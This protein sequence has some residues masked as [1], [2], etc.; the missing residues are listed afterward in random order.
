CR[1]GSPAAPAPDAAGQGNPR[2]AAVSLRA[3]G[4]PVVDLLLSVPPVPARALRCLDPIRER[5]A[6]LLCEAVAAAAL[7]TALADVTGGLWVRQN[8]GS[9]LRLEPD[10]AV[11]REAAQIVAVRKARFFAG[12]RTLTRDLRLDQAAVDELG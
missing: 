3:A 2:P 12:L 5:R 9:V 10:P 1:A 6:S 4:E 7:R 8:N 11:D